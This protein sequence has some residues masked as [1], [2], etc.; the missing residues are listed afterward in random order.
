MAD[1]NVLVYLARYR[2]LPQ[3]LRAMQHL[4]IRWEHS[5]YRVA[6]GDEPYDWETWAQFWEIIATRMALRTLKLQLFYLGPEADL[7][8]DAPWVAPMLMVG[9]VQEVEVAAKSRPMNN[10]VLT[11]RSFDEQL[12]EVM[13]GAR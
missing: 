10:Q 7:N 12:R 9:G 5:Q 11:V 8:I 3:R 6:S 1:L 4:E 13:M 2:L